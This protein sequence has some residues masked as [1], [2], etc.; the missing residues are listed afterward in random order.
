MEIRESD[1]LLDVEVIRDAD[2]GH[3]REIK[4]K[5]RGLP[6]GLETIFNGRGSLIAW[7]EMK[8]GSRHGKAVL[9]SNGGQMASSTLLE[10]GSPGGQFKIWSSSGLPQQAGSHKNGMLHGK[11]KIWVNGKLIEESLWRN[12]RQHGVT[13][14]FSEDGTLL[15]LERWEHGKLIERRKED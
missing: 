10:E 1:S 11:L 8:K 9:W 12:G 13:K 5:E 2:D 15:S 6:H 3:L 7:T 4:S 14:I